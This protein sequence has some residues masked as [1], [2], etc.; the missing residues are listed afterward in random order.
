MNVELLGEATG[1]L[2]LFL[3]NRLF[4]GL[5]ID[6][7]WLVTYG[8]GRTHYWREPVPATSQIHLRILNDRH[9]T[10]FFYSVDGQ[11]WTRHGLRMESSGYNANTILPGEGESLRPAIFSA[12]EGAVR[13]KNYRYHAL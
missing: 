4:L 5:G 2:L 10:T 13:F 9:I 11:A 6:G 3:C 7:K 12:G 1:G 8:G